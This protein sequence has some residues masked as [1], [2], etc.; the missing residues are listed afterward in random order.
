M[1][2]PFQF[3][4]IVTG[5]TYCKLQLDKREIKA[6]IENN[7]KLFLYSERRLGKTSLIKEIMA[8]LPKSKRISVYVDLYPTDGQLTFASTMAEAITRATSR[9]VEQF[10]EK[11]SQFFKK[12]HPSVSFDSAGNPT[13]KLEPSST[14]LPEQDF[15][16]ILDVPAKLAANS[17]KEVLIVFDEFQ[18]IAEYGNDYVERKIRSVIQH[19]DDVA[20]IFMGSKKHL[21]KTM[22]L[23]RSSPLYR[24]AKQYSLGPIALKD[25]APFIKEKFSSSDKEIE[26]ENIES[27]VTKTEGHPFYTQHLCYE[28][29]EICPVGTSVDTAMIEEAIEQLLAHEGTAFTTIWETC[30]TNQRR[31]LRALALEDFGVQIYS[32]DIAQRYRLGTASSTQRSIDALTERDLVDLQNDSY[33]ISDR[34]FRL[35]IRKNMG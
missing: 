32:S 1:R 28:L 22:F 20:Y 16:E 6:Y 29:W 26:Q 23:E 19:H 14:E 12:F 35:W 5:K 7:Q 33:Y 31:L 34:F 4:D 27:I 30:T 9:S 17:G 3:G 11:A 18:Q 24:S 13:F 15:E 2:N 10:L 8:K 21:I 25:W